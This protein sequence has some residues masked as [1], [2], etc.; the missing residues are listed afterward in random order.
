MKHFCGLIKLNEWSSIVDGAPFFIN[1]VMCTFICN[2]KVDRERFFL[3]VQFGELPSLNAT[4]VLAAL[5]RNN[6][7]GYIGEGPGFSISPTTGKLNYCRHF[8][9]VDADPETLANV[10]VYL[11]S[12]AIEWRTTYFLDT[13][14]AKKSKI[15]QLLINQRIHS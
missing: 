7:L 3:F 2:P 13:T 8:K 4:E 14:N 15:H 6:H 10:V 11:A 5:L 9:I 12:K 1:E